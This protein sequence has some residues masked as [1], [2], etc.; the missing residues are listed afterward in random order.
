MDIHTIVFILKN[1]TQ[2]PIPKNSFLPSARLIHLLTE[3]QSFGWKPL[4]NKSGVCFLDMNEWKL[5]IHENTILSF[6]RITRT[7]YISPHTS[8]KKIDAMEHFALLIGA[9][10]DDCPFRK[11]ADIYYTNIKKQEEI[12]SY[13]KKLSRLNP[14]TP[15][16]D[17]YQLFDWGVAD[18]NNMLSA[19]DMHWSA[20]GEITIGRYYI[21]RRRN[22]ND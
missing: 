7:G 6:I 3:P 15:E 13:N 14:M 4:Q 9:G 19:N 2:L 1:K 17:M 16:E 18:R 21:R 12:K 22:I 8:K 20:T 5:N 11:A 10:M